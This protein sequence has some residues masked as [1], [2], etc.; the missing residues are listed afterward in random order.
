MNEIEY[1]CE[2]N[3][4]GL[5]HSIHDGCSLCDCE[6]NRAEVVTI[7]QLIHELNSLRKQLDGVKNLAKEVE[8]LIIYIQHNNYKKAT[9][10][11]LVVETHLAEL[12]TIVK[13]YN[14]T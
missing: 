7:G 8:D 5:M 9:L 4:T 2:C 14:V 1:V 10:Q 12:G 6:R 11:L 3:H 13:E